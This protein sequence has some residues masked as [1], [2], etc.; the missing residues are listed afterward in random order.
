MNKLLL[1]RTH[2][3]LL[4]VLVVLICVFVIEGVYFITIMGHNNHDATSIWIESSPP[5]AIAKD[6]TTVFYPFV[7]KVLIPN[8]LN[9]P[10]WKVSAAFGVLQLIVGVSVMAIRGYGAWPVIFLLLAYFMAFIRYSAFVRKK[11]AAKF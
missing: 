10:H 6:N 4:G 2:R 11:A 7:L 5:S 1:H 9:I 8:E 3:V